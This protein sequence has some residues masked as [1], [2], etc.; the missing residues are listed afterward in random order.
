MVI[1]KKRVF[2]LIESSSGMGWDFL[3][4]VMSYVRSHQDWIID[5][6]DHRTFDPLPANLL[7]GRWD[8][9]I[10]RSVTMPAGGELKKR[11]RYPC[12]TVELLGDSP[13]TE[14]RGDANSVLE[15]AVRHAE[16][17]GYNKIA[18]YSNFNCF[19]MQVRSN[20]LTDLCRQHG[21]G[22][23]LSPDIEKQNIILPTFEWTLEDER[24]LLAWLPT[25]PK[26]VII[27]AIF[28][29]QGVQ[30]INAC[31][32]LSF[33]IPNEVA[34]LSIGNNQRLCEAISP[35]LSSIDLVSFQIGYESARLLDLKMNGQP[36][37]ELPITI[38]PSGLIHRESTP[39]AQIKDKEIAQAIAMIRDNAIFGLSVRDIHNQL[40][41]APRTLE[42][43]IKKALGRTPK[44]EIIRVRL[45]HAVRLIETSDVSVSEIARLSGFPSRTSFIDSFVTAY[46]HSPQEHRRLKRHG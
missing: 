37:P 6:E 34:V 33:S 27:C 10:F 14:V 38:Q 20:L 42:R 26:P 28:D 9:V 23:I 24:K 15:L 2:L 25:L 1:R 22:C 29:H 46:G 13:A 5:F 35:T 4:G 31:K 40:Q 41:I 39:T 44:S 36:L 30:I 12:P 3:Q 7:E 16:E 18:F 11:M 19:W 43:G 45:E 21:I 8:G 32:K 17:C